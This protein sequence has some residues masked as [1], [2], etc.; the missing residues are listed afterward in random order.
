MNGCRR[1]D[2][3]PGLTV[4]IVLNKTKAQVL[5]KGLLKTSLLI[6]PIIPVA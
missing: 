2:I 4:D 6:L 5:T 3:K 1:A